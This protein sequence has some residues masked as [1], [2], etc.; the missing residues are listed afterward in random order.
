M[1][2]FADFAGAPINA[3]GSKKAKRLVTSTMLD[4]QALN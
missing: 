4:H 1:R 2:I 3:Q